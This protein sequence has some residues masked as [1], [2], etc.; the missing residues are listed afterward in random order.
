[1]T[2]SAFNAHNRRSSR[3]VLVSLFFALQ[4]PTAHSTLVAHGFAM[5]F[6]FSSSVYSNNNT[7]T[8]SRTSISLRQQN[9]Q[10]SRRDYC[11]SKIDFT[12]EKLQ[13]MALFKLLIAYYGLHDSVCTVASFTL[14]MF[15]T[16]LRR[17]DL[18]LIAVRNS[19]HCASNALMTSCLA[20]AIVKHFAY[21]F[22]NGKYVIVKC[23]GIGSAWTRKISMNGGVL[24]KELDLP[25]N[26]RDR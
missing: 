8:A 25:K 10:N 18:S 4:I 15:V 7:L 14:K 16:M 9:T 22:R 24:R 26:K 12:F 3:R 20:D 13:L 21:Q 5:R 17:A 19:D 1:M 6:S 11:N 2:S 23:G